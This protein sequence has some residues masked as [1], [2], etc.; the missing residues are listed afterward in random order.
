MGDDALDTEGGGMPTIG[1]GFDRGRV[2]TCG[3]STRLDEAE[4]WLRTGVSSEGCGRSK[5]TPL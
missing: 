2:L 4:S 5:V 1:G 3:V